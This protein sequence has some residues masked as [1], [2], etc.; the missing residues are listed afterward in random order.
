MHDSLF[1]FAQ[2]NKHAIY[3]TATSQT[4]QLSEIRTS[5]SPIL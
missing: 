2:E 5:I 4:D 1:L 3:K